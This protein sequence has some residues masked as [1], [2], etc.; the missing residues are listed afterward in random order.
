M[1]ISNPENFDPYHKW[2]GIPK[3]KQPPNHYEL[4]GISLNEDDPEVIESAA[5]QR[6]QY[7]GSKRG[8]GMDDAVS[9]ISF[10]IDE[11]KLTLLD[12]AMRRDYD[13]RKNLFDKRNRNRQFDSI[14]G[15]LPRKSGSRKARGGGSKRGR[16]GTGVIKFVVVALV[17]L[18][19]VKF[20]KPW[21]SLTTTDAL[22]TN[23]TS[24]IEEP[25][26]VGKTTIKPVTTTA[27]PP[28]TPPVTPST[29]SPEKGN[30]ASSSANSPPDD[31]DDIVAVAVRPE[32]P[33]RFRDAETSA[34]TPDPGEPVT[35]P[36]PI[37]EVTF[38]EQRKPRNT[39]V[40]AVRMLRGR[41][42]KAVHFN[43]SSHVSLPAKLPHGNSPRTISVWLRNQGESK[44]T[45]M[46]VIA[47]GASTATARPC[48]IHH[49]SGVWAC[50]GWLN[51]LSLDAEVDREWHHHCMAYDGKQIVYYF[52]GRVVGQVEGI[53]ETAEDVLVLGTY[54]NPLGPDNS[55]TG[56][57]DE[58]R[59]YAVGLTNAQTQ[60]LY[61]S[62]EPSSDEE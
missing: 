47:Y 11:A 22:T 59:I 8:Q 14:G 10:K 24:N 45:N 35:L 18:I 56:Y 19:V 54:A 30:D 20:W 13:Q 32:L 12:P 58:L 15:V 5:E 33:I 39:T 37:F 50:Y 7:V 36:S 4:L 44:A 52:D 61:Q 51:E 17:A 1:K 62:Y 43:G 26:A 21:E 55:F 46:H 53:L 41:I 23:A 6:K 57:I 49:N 25:Q 27:T 29:N 28:L 2:L 48:G 31:E 42:G 34:P 40:G 16:N 3:N 9:S 38:D 60:Q